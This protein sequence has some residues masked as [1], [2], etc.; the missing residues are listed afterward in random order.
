MALAQ[1]SSES[2]AQLYHGSWNA[3][4][5]ASLGG[6]FETKPVCF[7]ARFESPSSW[8]RPPHGAHR[9]GMDVAGLSRAGLPVGAP[10]GGFPRTAMVLRLPAVCRKSLA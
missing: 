7:G 4:A 10:S 9:L 1:F 3:P 5:R 2:I 6:I 8:C